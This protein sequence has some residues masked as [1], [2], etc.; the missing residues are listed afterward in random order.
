MAQQSMVLLGKNT[1]IPSIPT[2]EEWRIYGN[3]LL[4]IPVHIRHFSMAALKTYFLHTSRECSAAGVAASVIYLS[5]IRHFSRIAQAKLMDV[6]SISRQTIYRISKE[7]EEILIR[8][9][10]PH[11][12]ISILGISLPVFDDGPLLSVPTQKTMN[13]MLGF[14]VDCRIDQYHLVFDLE[15]ANGNI[16]QLS[17]SISVIEHLFDLSR[18]KYFK[19]MKRSPELIRADFM[20]MYST[21]LFECRYVQQT[22][23]IKLINC[24]PDSFFI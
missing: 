10:Y 19:I 14:L 15:T 24:K 20:Q 6:F 1:E 4:K 7:M 13:Q 11:A 3:R 17:G 22:R 21:R 18:S 23:K 16:V 9:F 8:E 5:S 2:A 12:K